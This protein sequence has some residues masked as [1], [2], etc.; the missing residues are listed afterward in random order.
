MAGI[1]WWTTDIGGFGGGDPDDPAYRELLIRWFQWGAFCPVFRLHGFRVSRSPEYAPLHTSGTSSEEVFSGGPNEVWSYGEEAYEILKKFLF[2]R[3]HMRPYIRQLMKAAHEKGTPIMRPVFYD[4]PNDERAWD[5]PHEYM[6][7]PDVL[8]APV[9]FPGIRTRSV[10][11]PA[12][13]D[14]KDVRS[15]LIRRGGETLEVE[16]P[17]DAI[18]VFVRRGVELP[19]FI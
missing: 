16:A 18:P 11:L 6:F 10:Y 19:I 14:W 8:V 2:L 1:P 7:G 9:M 3:E 5:V 15:G 17:L 13:A 12:G 4:F